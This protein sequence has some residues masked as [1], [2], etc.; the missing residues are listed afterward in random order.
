MRGK[1]RERRG[2]GVWG[3]EVECEEVE[4]GVW[5][6]EVECGERR[7]SVGGGGGVWGRR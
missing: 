2:G 3:E 7:W 4:C 1:W 6:E 5:R